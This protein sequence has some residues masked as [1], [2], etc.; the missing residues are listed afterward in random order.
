MN[1]TQKQKQRKGVLQLDP[2]Y[3]PPSAQLVPISWCR[4]SAPALEPAYNEGGTE[5]PIQKRIEQGQIET[6]NKNKKEKGKVDSKGG[7]CVIP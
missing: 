6:G 5:G 1:I 7:T 2:D 3:V 4:I